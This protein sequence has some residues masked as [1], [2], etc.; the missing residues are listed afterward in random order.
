MATLYSNLNGGSTSD[1]PLTSGATTLNSA[2][3][4]FLPAV[5]G[6]DVL[7]LTLDPTGA[8]GDPEIVKVTAHTASATSATIVRAQQSTT[9]RSHPLATTWVHAL[10]TT[11]IAAWAANAANIAT[12]A[13]DIATNTADIATNAADIA[14]EAARPPYLSVDVSGTDVVGVATLTAVS[15]DTETTD[16]DSIAGASTVTIGT[17]G[18]YGLA[19]LVSMDTALTGTVAIV[20]FYVLGGP[21]IQASVDVAAGTATEEDSAPSYLS[22][23]TE[24]TFGW[25]G[26]SG[27]TNTPTMSWQF[28][29]YRLA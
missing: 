4:E 8:S 29:L 16:V 21:L 12:N 17:S 22:A 5:T 9:A 19:A 20:T 23:G 27:I 18:W 2:G 24:L 6:S 10:T 7:Y 3:L 15:V 1:N 26:S 14:T 25:T 11:D 28:L 13:A